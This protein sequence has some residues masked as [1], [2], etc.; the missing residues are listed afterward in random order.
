MYGAMIGDIVGS[1]YEFSNI[2]TK[3]FPFFT[4][5]CDYTDDT[6]LS[7]AVAKAILLSRTECF[8]HGNRPDARTFESF[9]ID[10]LQDF[11]HRYPDPKGAYGGGFSMWLHSR[12]PKPYHSYGNGSAMRASACGIVAV[13]MM[14][15][16]NLAR[17]SAQVTHDHPEGIKGAQAV[18]AAVYMAKRYYKKDEIRDYIQENFYDLSQTLDEIRPGYVF[19]PSCQGTVPQ[20]L[21]A[22]LESSSFEDAIRNAVS[23]GGDSDTIAAITGAVAWA[24]YARENRY[25]DRS[26]EN[27]L[28]REL[29]NLQSQAKKFLPEEFVQ[30]AQELHTAS[31][32]RDGVYDRV[33]M[34]TGI[35]QEREYQQQA[36]EPSR[37]QS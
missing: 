15:A 36:E 7:I 4:P 23:I 33:G 27:D 29:Q 25:Y 18:A 11:G 31:W 20:A 3:D 14:E 37:K 16:L 21:I 5:G 28:H 9:V 30:I 26:A 24:Y 17:V 34:C 10:Q 13:N 32:Q 12:N 8:E 2:K 6:I 19:D 35:L 1:A 22:F